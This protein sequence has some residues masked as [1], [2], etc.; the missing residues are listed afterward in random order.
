MAMDIEDWILGEYDFREVAKDMT[1]DEAYEQMY[2]QLWVED[3]VTGNASGSYTCNAY[4]AE[5][6]LAGNWDL[7]GEALD[8]FCQNDVRVIK[9]GAEWCDVTIRC[10]LLGEV[11]YTVLQGLYKEFKEG[12]FD[13]DFDAYAEIFKDRENDY[14]GN[15][16]I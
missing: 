3:Q 14:E 13:D 7:L 6:Y 9:K 15:E 1:I 16:G 4:M 11:L 5:E 12:L 8:E 10:Y 2:E